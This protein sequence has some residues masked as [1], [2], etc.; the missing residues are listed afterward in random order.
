MKDLRT[1]LCIRALIGA[2]FGIF[3]CLFFMVFMSDGDEVIRGNYHLILQFFGS[4]LYGAI[5]MAGT[6][7]FEKEEWGLLKVTCIHYLS[8]FIAFIIANFILDWFEWEVFGIVVAIMTVLYFIIWLI[9]YRRYKSEIKRIN[10]ELE[11]E[12]LL[13]DDKGKGERD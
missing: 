7:V 3:I 2:L 9:Q 13:R 1:R 5:P 8:T 11:T 10:D 12:L 6:V 4:A